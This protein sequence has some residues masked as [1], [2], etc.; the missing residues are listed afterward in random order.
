MKWKEQGWVGYK[1][2]LGVSETVKARSAKLFIFW[3][4]RGNTRENINLEFNLILQKFLG[5]VI[6]INLHII[7]SFFSCGLKLTLLLNVKSIAHYANLRAKF[8]LNI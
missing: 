7:F 6:S 5:V 8:K 2:L 4:S 3:S 1:N